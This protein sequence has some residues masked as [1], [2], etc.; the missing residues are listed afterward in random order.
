MEKVTDIFLR[1]EEFWK[2]PKLRKPKKFRRPTKQLQKFRRPTKQ[3]P[4]VSWVLESI[5]S[6]K[7]EESPRT[8]TKGKTSKSQLLEAKKSRCSLLESTALSHKRPGP[9]YTAGGHKSPGIEHQRPEVPEWSTRA[10]KVPEPLEG[11]DLAGQQEA[12]S[13]NRLRP[14]K[15]PNV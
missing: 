8:T 5:K 13:P 1:S 12:P 14:G 4:E 3:L 15:S 11:R 10:Q 6:F 7:G 2:T 9:N